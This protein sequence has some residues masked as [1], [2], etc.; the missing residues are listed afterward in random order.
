M[1]S[2]KRNERHAKNYNV[3]I[4]YLA[5]EPIKPQIKLQPTKIGPRNVWKLQ[6]GWA[7]VFL[8][9][10]FQQ[11]RFSCSFSVKYH[12]VIPEPIHSDYISFKGRCS[13]HNRRA[14]FFGVKNEPKPGENVTVNFL[15]INTTGIEH[16]KKRFL[17][18]PKRSFI[19]EDI[20]NSGAS[21]WRRKT[22]DK[23]IDYG[24]VEPPILYKSSVLRKAKQ[25]HIDSKLGIDGSDPINSIVA[26]KHEVEYSGQFIILVV[27]HFFVTIGCLL[28]SIST[29]QN[30]V[31]HGRQ[32]R[33]MLQDPQCYLL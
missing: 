30:G 2:L 8:D 25:Q 19:S 26:L 32:Y 21:Q 7:D 28:K 22:V 6:K 18:Q 15:A 9:H 5:Y 12:H 14:S 11:Y 1:K 3:T 24:E 20:I 16:T 27:I 17:K 31:R 13:D 10:F 4:P 23:L 33:L 29:K